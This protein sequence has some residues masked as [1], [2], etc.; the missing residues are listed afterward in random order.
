M[1]LEKFWQ[2]YKKYLYYN[3][4]LG[5]TLDISRVDFREGYFSEME[6]KIAKAYKAMEEL[7]AGAIANPDENRMVGHYWLRAPHLC[8]QKISQEITGHRE[9][10]NFRCN[11]QGKF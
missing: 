8:L 11:C 6:E 9:I 3:Q 7:E 10:Q 5:L 4:E 1:E 2:R